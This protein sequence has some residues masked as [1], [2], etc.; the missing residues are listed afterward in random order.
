MLRCSLALCIFVLGP[1]AAAADDC[2]ALLPT[3]IV[4]TGRSFDLWPL[5]ARRLGRI[6]SYRL[7]A[8]D[9]YAISE[10]ITHFVTDGTVP[11]GEREVDARARAFIEDLVSQY[12]LE[13]ARQRLVVVAYTLRWFNGYADQ[14]WAIFLERWYLIRPRFVSPE[15]MEAEGRRTRLLFWTFTRRGDTEPIEEYARDYIDFNLPPEAVGEE[16]IRVQEA[17]REANQRS[18]DAMLDSSLNAE[19]N[20]KVEYVRET[21]DDIRFPGRFLEGAAAG[22]TG[23]GSWDGIFTRIV[24]RGYGTEPEH[25]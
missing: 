13:E 8:Y 7:N 4:E 6:S 18:A 19:G 23:A 17:N 15:Y 5:R 3:C 1:I 16:I 20:A 22:Q 2:D 25:E 21:A 10:R 11:S 12:P 9:D 24:Q 14:M